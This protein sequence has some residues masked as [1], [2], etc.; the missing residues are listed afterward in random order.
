MSTSS[1][2]HFLNSISMCVVFAISPPDILGKLM[3][4]TLH[5]IGT[6]LNFTIFLF[7]FIFVIAIVNS[8]LEQHSE[9]RSRRNQLIYSQALTQNKI[10]RHGSRSRSRE[11]FHMRSVGLLLVIGVIYCIGKCTYIELHLEIHGS[12][13]RK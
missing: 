1:Q 11:S 6:W 8:R 5:N 4:G 7:N 12:K 3:H 13:T 10:D 9:K 2:S